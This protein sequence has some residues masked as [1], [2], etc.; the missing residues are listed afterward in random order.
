M[1]P[2]RRSAAGAANLVLI[3]ALLVAGGCRPSSPGSDPPPRGADRPAPERPSL[4]SEITAD[5]GLSDTACA[6]PDGA[7]RL[8][9]ITG[10]GVG[11]LDF[12]NDGDLDILQPRMPPPDDPRAP[13]PNRLYQQQSDGTFRDVT[14]A[15]GLGDPGFGQGAAVGDVDNDGDL[16]VYFTNYGPDALYLNRGDGSFA[17]VTAPAGIAGDLWSTSAAFCDYD[18]DGLLD[19]YVA[20][21]LW[22]DPGVTCGGPSGVRDYCDPINFDG[23]PDTLYRNNG[24]GTFTD[25]TVEAGLRLPEGGKTAKG[26]GLICTDLT[27]DGLVDFYV[28][29]DGQ[30]NNLWVNRGDGTF[31]DQALPL[32][33]AVNR[34]G[35]PEAS[36]GVTVG[37]VDAN[38]AHDLFLTHLETETNTLYSGSRP[39][40]FFDRSLES[41]LATY[42]R[43]FTGFGCGFFDYDHDGDLD[44]AVVNGRVNRGPRFESA[45]LGDFWSSY[46]EPNFL[47][48]N[49]GSGTFSDASLRAGEFSSRVEVTR[50]LAFGDLDG[51]GDLDL[52]LSNVDNLLRVFRNDAP[53]PGNHWLMVRAIT[54]G[55]DALGAQ[56]TARAGDR[57]FLGF[58]LAGYSFASSNDPRAHLGLG[59]VDRIDEIEILWSDGRRERFRPDGVDRVLTLRRGHGEAP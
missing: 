10:P 31:A 37:D 34:H 59:S 13:A 43:P 58:V 1:R 12:D 51:D 35:E 56:V 38:G 5:V 7:F 48:E 54:R 41:G 29:N 14:S 32:G 33:L 52:V 8:T 53:R 6:W 25:V 55:R 26:L 27:H 50:G 18:G 17:D 39:S 44:L 45:D 28:A 2:G 3:A 16:D 4:F 11:L 30:P 21:Y 40:L 20:H 47:F 36:M 49:R 15:A 57:E 24:D 42:D 23:V 46:A 9:E 19:L 22:L